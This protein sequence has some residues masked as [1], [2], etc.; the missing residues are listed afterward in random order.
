MSESDTELSSLDTVFDI[1]SNPRRRFV[2]HYL[3]QREEPVGLNELAAEIAAREN[4]VPVDELTSQQRKRAYVSL[5]QTHVPKLE[6]VGV[7]TYDSESGEVAL[8]DRADEIG[9]HLE[10]SDSDVSW[11]RWYL[12]V[13]VA[14]I[15]AIGLTPIA[16]G[17]TEDQFRVGLLVLGAIA[18]I[19]IANYAYARRSAD[20]SVPLIEEE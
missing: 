6:E 17:G 2:L 20:R 5:Y 9:E 7:V 11:Q 15:V 14:G 8:T 19:A 18:V 16:G 3:E 1:L 12:L 4:D 10:R 13:A